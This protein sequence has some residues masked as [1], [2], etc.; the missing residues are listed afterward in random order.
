MFRLLKALPLTLAIAAL[1]IATASCGA[2]STQVRVLN[3][4]DGT[5][6]NGGVSVEVNGVNT[7]S[8]TI[9]FGDVFPTQKSSGPA[10]YTSV[11]SGRDTIQ[12]FT[13]G[14]TSNPILTNTLSL[15]GGD[16]Y[17]LVLGPDIITPFLDNNTVP[18]TNY[19]EFRVIDASTYDTFPVDVYLVPC[20][21]SSITTYK[22]G[23]I[24]YAGSINYQSVEYNAVTCPEGGNYEFYV[25]PTGTQTNPYVSWYYTAP[26]GSITTLVI[27]DNESSGQAV[28][29]SGQ[30]LEWID[31][32]GG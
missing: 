21:A 31:L 6:I 22:I 20:G 23:T 11:P 8:S 16:Q 12:V 19:L 2:N 29:I 30:P 18:T 17:T 13:A 15:D 28:G 24:Q 5:A 32:I 7:F 3:A 27:Q 1:S 25:F 9:T 10:A 4:M 26:A 14:N